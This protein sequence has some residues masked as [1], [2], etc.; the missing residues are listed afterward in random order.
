V[1]SLL[2]RNSKFG[3]RSPRG[4]LR[5]LGYPGPEDEDEHEDEPLNS[6][7]GSSK[8]PKGGDRERRTDSK[9]KEHHAEVAVERCGLRADIGNNSPRQILC[10]SCSDIDSAPEDQDLRL[11]WCLKGTKLKFV[12]WVEQS[13]ERRRLGT[14]NKER[15]TANEFAVH[16]ASIAEICSGSKMYILP[17]GS[18]TTSRTGLLRS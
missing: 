17:L 13:T 4:R 10:S 1:V 15:R 5:I 6:E 2:T 3:N 16:F 9:T 7:F 18:K 14:V 8:A 12:I 11:K